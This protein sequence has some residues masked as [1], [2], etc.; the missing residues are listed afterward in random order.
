MGI[1]NASDLDAA[2]GKTIKPQ[3][4]PKHTGGDQGAMQARFLASSDH[5]EQQQ[6]YGRRGAAVYGADEVPERGFYGSGTIISL[7]EQP[8]LPEELAPQVERAAP[9]PAPVPA[10]AA[11]MQRQRTPQEIVASLGFVKRKQP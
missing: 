4:V 8:P 6:G 10:P 1:V 3:E 9:M 5:I 11:P 7:N 2:M